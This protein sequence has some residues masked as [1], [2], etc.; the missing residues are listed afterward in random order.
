M[1]LLISDYF[2][3]DSF[4]KLAAPGFGKTFEYRLLELINQAEMNDWLLA[5][6]AAAHERRPKNADLASIAEEAGLTLTGPR[7]DNPTGVSLQTLIQ[8]QAKFLDPVRFREGLAILEGQVCWIDVPVGGGGTGF[9]IASNL[10]VTNQH[11]VA[12]VMAGTTRW[13]DV[14]CQ[15]DFK[16]SVDGSDLVRRNPTEVPLSGPDWLV[17]G[18]EPSAADEDPALGE[19]GP[20]ETDCAVI[21]LA[22]AIGDQPVGGDTVDLDAQPRS[23]VDV[24]R[25]APPVSVGNQVFLLQHPVGQPLAMAIGKV[26]AF[27]SV[28]TRMRYDANSKVGSSGAPVFDADLQLVALHHARDVGEPPAWNQAVPFGAIQDVWKKH[29]VPLD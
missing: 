20:E 26:V 22:E 25:P 23:W 28:G 10:V 7:M 2:E 19:A 14:R 5:L 13:Q 17:D 29:A 8:Q 6:V 16:R 15:F 4:Q 24:A 18:R 12:A 1:E 3:P 27:N 21:R 11:V 9:L